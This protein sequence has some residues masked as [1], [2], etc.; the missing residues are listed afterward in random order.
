[1][2]DSPQ[3]NTINL[4]VGLFP[5]F[6]GTFDYPSSS[7]DVKLILVVPEKPRVAFLQEFYFRMSYFNNLWSLP[8]PSA[9]MEGIGHHGMAMP[10]S[11]IEVA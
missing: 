9:S 6:M 2:I 7:G 10:L 1:M 5:L 8:S 4:G 3:P 11:T